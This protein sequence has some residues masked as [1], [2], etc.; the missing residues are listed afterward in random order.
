[1]TADSLT[2]LDCGA[3]WH[4]APAAHASARAGGCLVC[5]GRL[6]PASEAE[7]LEEQGSGDRDDGDAGA[8]G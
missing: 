2:C 4:S 1:M 5:G 3:V 7:R 8:N 6:L